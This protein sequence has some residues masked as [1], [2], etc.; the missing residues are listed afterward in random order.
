MRGSKPLEYDQ[1]KMVN[2]DEKT[3][4]VLYY[5]YMAGLFLEN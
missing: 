3:C 5:E 1:G 4:C 2:M